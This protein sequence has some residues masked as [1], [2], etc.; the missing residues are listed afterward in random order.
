[1]NGQLVNGGGLTSSV[2]HDEKPREKAT[3]LEILWSDVI[4]PAG[5]TLQSLV[6]DLASLICQIFSENSESISVKQILKQLTGDILANFIEG[7]R[8]VV[9]GIVGVIKTF[10]EEFKDLINAKIT[11][12]VFSGLYKT[13]FS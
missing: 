9:V 1:M 8:K 13:L 5:E 2:I 10:V 7:I 12:P 11:I 3:S 4:I 6:L